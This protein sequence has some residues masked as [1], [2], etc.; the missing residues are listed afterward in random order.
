VEEQRKK[1]EK[2]EQDRKDKEWR[3]R[4]HVEA[5]VELARAAK[6][7]ED[8]ME[9]ESDWKCDVDVTPR[10]RRDLFGDSEGDSDTDEEV[11]LELDKKSEDLKEKEWVVA[12]KETKSAEV[13]FAMARGNLTTAVYT[14]GYAPSE[15]A[16]QLLV[17]WREELRGAV[18]RLRTAWAQDAM[19][20]TSVIL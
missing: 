13:H 8:E 2:E 19:L 14:H 18:A 3:N 15:A 12:H 9:V 6:E 16:D 20:T 7:L 11:D 5:E 17:K 10:A 1:K 4:E